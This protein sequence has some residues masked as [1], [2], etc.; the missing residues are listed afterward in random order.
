M[1]IQIKSLHDII[2]PYLYVPQTRPRSSPLL[3][4]PDSRCSL[5]DP[6]FAPTS[7]TTVPQLQT[8]NISRWQTPD[9]ETHPVLSCSR[10]SFSLRTRAKR[11][12]VIYFYRANRIKC[13]SHNT[14]SAINQC[15]DNYVAVID[16]SYLRVIDIPRETSKHVASFSGCIRTRGDELY[17]VHRIASRSTRLAIFVH[18]RISE[19]KSRYVSRCGATKILARRREMKP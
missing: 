17:I 18:D 11:Y 15:Y 2:Y 6:H 16:M 9:K 7:P 5:E 8:D 14:R 12:R 13:M 19:R 1:M 3:P 10:I 4:P